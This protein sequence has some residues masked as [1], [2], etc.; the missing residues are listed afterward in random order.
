MLQIKSGK[1]AKPENIS[2]KVLESGV[3]VKMLHALQKDI[4]GNSYDRLHC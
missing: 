1:S 4:I 3:T 2:T